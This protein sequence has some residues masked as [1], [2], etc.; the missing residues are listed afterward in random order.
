MSYPTQYTYDP[1]DRIS[2]ITYPDGRVVNYTRDSLGRITT[3]STT[4][5]GSSQNIVSARTYRPDGLLTGETFG[6]GISET[7]QYDLQGRPTLQFLGNADT[8]VYSYDPNSNL[9]QEQSLPQV[10]NYMY[11]S[12]DRLNQETLTAK[13]TENLNYGYDANG[14]RS[15]L[16]TNNKTGFY[17][18]TPNSNRLVNTPQGSVTLDSMG[19]TLTDAQGR[20]FSYTNAG[21]LAHVIVRGKAVGSYTYN[22]Q[23]Q[24]TRKI[25]TRDTIVYHYDLGGNLILE[26]N[27]NGTPIKAYVWADNQPLAQIDALTKGRNSSE[28]ILYLHTDHL[29]TPRLATDSTQA[30]QWRWDGSAFG[31]A[32]PTGRATINLRRPGEYVDEESNLVH[33]GYRTLDTDIDRYLQSDPMGLGGGSNT[34][35][36]VR[37]NPLRYIDPM[38]LKVFCMWDQKTGSFFCIDT[39]TDKP[40]ADNT[41]FSGKQGPSRN[42]PN[43]QN[44]K[45]KGPLPRGWWD[46][47]L[48]TPMSNP[49]ILSPTLPLTPA[50]SNNSVFNTN[51]DPFSF[52][53]H[54]GNPAADPSAGCLICNRN[55]RNI[56]NQHGGG[57]LLV[58]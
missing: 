41:C 28:Q 49:E 47:G 55:I 53:M 26:T 16:T 6:N 5:N 1:A 8:R 3:V 52:W 14:N 2:S 20:N 43:A 31:N 51:R 13:N 34:F 48:D 29:H 9:T 33:N 50:I 30:V 12:L 57:D 27:A 54:G 39:D 36:H 22:A 24:R 10:G 17:N 21:Q 11:D 18:Y 40:L 32:S 25:T 19:N 46:I 45:D 42:N 7:R 58:R 23:H 38:G 44:E 15:T 4:V 35:I 37:D 56:I